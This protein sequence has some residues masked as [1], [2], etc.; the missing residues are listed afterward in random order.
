[1]PY[2]NILVHADLSRPV[3]VLCLDG[4]APICELATAVHDADLA[5]GPAAA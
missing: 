2:K 3:N 5:A 4:I 1:M